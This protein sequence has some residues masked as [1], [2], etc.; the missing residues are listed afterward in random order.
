MAFRIRFQFSQ[1]NLCKMEMDTKAKSLHI[2]HGSD[3]WTSIRPG[4]LL[5]NTY[6][7]RPLIIQSGL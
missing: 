6:F 3:W 2:R 1:G 4:I 5:V 7:S